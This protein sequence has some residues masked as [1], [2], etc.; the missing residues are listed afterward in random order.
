MNSTFV[1]F[2]KTVESKSFVE[3][4]TLHTRI[5]TR[6]SLKIYLEVAQYFSTVVIFYEDIEE[7]GYFV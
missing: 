1:K 6:C 7:S 4:C 2:P 5:L 3:N